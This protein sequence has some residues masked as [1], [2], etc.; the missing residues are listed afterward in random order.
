[1]IRIVFVV[2]SNKIDELWLETETQATFLARQGAY[3]LDRM[4]WHNHSGLVTGDWQCTEDVLKAYHIAT[5]I[6]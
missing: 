2:P 5:S 4:G 3:G 6:N 1:M